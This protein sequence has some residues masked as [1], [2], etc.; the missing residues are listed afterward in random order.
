MERINPQILK[1]YFKNLNNLSWVRSTLTPVSADTPRLRT[2]NAKT[3]P[4]ATAN[5]PPRLL[6]KLEIIRP[7]LSCWLW[8]VR[9]PHH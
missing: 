5:T 6:T 9:R 8:I 2:M 3:A 7:S 4:T 1:N